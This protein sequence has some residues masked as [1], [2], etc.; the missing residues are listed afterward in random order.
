MAR[1]VFEIKEEISKLFEEFESN[2]N[3]FEQKGNK[4]AAQRA[5]KALGDLKKLVTEYRQASVEQTKK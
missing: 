5:R 3:A 4:S 1:N 2:H